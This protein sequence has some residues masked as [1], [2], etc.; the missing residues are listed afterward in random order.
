VKSK[1]AAKRYRL[2]IQGRDHKQDISSTSVVDEGQSS[3]RAFIHPLPA[4]SVEG[5]VSG[6]SNC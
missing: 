4:I 2:E 3:C 5:N 1:A 6:I